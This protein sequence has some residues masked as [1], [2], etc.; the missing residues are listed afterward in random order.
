VAV[1]GTFAALEVL[2]FSLNV[3]TLLALVLSIGL[4]V[5][6]AIVVMENVYRR[7]ELGEGRL[8]AALRGSQ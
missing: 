3:L 4:V 2:G 5:D 6:D 1:I 8:A 7:Q